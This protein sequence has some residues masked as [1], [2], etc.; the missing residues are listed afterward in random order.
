MSGKT[1]ITDRREQVRRLLIRGLSAKEIV[2]SL[3]NKWSLPTVNRDISEINSQRRKWWSENSTLN[4]RLGRYL[5]E[6]MDTFKEVEK[7]AWRIH[8]EADADNFRAKTSALALIIHA[9]EEINSTLGLSG[10]S[11]NEQEMQ[12]KIS[13]VETELSEIRGLLKVAGSN[14]ITS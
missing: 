4:E 1:V 8:Y 10:T 7:E 2:D 11:L 5:K 3:E 14:K 13:Q 6:R 12:E 9:E